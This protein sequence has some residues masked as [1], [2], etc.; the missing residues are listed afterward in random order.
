ML[1][2]PNDHFLA[3]MHKVLQG[4]T[5]TYKE[6]QETT[7]KYKEYFL[8]IAIKAKISCSFLYFE[9]LAKESKCKDLQESFHIVSWVFL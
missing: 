3:F 8:E 2:G 9:F 6:V 4:T 5:R 7:R 1:L